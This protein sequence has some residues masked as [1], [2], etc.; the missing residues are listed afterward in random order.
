MPKI[1]DRAARRRRILD[2]AG[3]VFARRGIAGTGLSHVAE[4]AGMRR[5]NL[6][7]YYPDKD[8]LIGALADALLADEEA[9]FQAALAGPGTALERLDRLVAGFA[10]LF[11]PRAALGRVLLEVWASSPRRMRRALRRVRASLADLVRGGQSAGELDPDLDADTAA[12]LLVALLD[13]LVVQMFLD[14]TR[15]PRGTTLR[16]ALTDAVRRA[17]TPG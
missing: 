7:H 1:V 13:G 17:L 6:Y 8:S 16:R 3:R 4:A 2:A 5:S 12:L 14:P 9:L 15:T 10:D 11:E